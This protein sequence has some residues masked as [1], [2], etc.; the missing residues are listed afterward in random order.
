M[1]ERKRRILSLIQKG[2]DEVGA[3]TYMGTFEDSEDPVLTLALTN[4]AGKAEDCFA[5]L[6][7][8]QEEDIEA[9]FSLICKI[10]LQSKVSS[11]YIQKLL[12]AMN[13]VN[14][15]IEMGAFVVDEDEK[16][17]KFRAVYPLATTLSDEEVVNKA[18]ISIGIAMTLAETYAEELLAIGNGKKAA[19][20]IFELL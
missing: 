16:S 7:M 13:A 14:H 12:L 17:L 5:D 9:F 20:T 10:D 2:Y 18:D 4:F 11:E 3:S 19:E 8:E 6:Y 1:E 15:S